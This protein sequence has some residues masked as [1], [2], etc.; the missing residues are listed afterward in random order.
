MSL[1][2]VMCLCGQLTGG[3]ANPIVTFGLLI[4]KGG[5]V[6][7]INAIVYIGSQFAGSFAGAAIG[8]FYN[9]TA[10]GIVDK[11]D[12]AM[13]TDGNSEAQIFGG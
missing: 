6:T 11:Y 5:K 9:Y 8:S 10:Y 3:H 12:C 4:T 13:P 7:L 1:F 2:L